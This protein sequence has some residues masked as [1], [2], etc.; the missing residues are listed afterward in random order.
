MQRDEYSDLIDDFPTMHFDRVHSVRSRAELTDLNLEIYL[1]LQC[2]A[3][4]GPD[5]RVSSMR[6]VGLRLELDSYKTM[7]Y[8]NEELQFLPWLITTF[9]SKLTVFPHLRVAE[10]RSDLNILQHAAKAAPKISQLPTLGGQLI[11]RWGCPQRDF[12]AVDSEEYYTAGVNPI[13]LE[14]SGMCVVDILDCAT[15]ENWAVR[16]LLES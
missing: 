8:T 13:T 4:R 7:Q 3:D 1:D 15:A 10:I 12:G 2:S 9:H 5:G 16:T 6:V 14:P 11:Y